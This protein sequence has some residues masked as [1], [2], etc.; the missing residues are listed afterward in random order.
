LDQDE[1]PRE[2]LRVLDLQGRWV[3]GDGAEREGRVAI[4]AEGVERVKADPPR[5]AED[6]DVE[7]E[8]RA[9]VAAA[10]EDR[11]QRDD[12]QE[13]ESDPEED[14]GDVMRDRQQPL[15]QP[16]PAA[17]RRVE[18]PFD[19]HRIDGNVWHVLL[20]LSV[21]RRRVPAWR[22]PPVWD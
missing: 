19:A 7:V 5:P 6:T 2:P 16:E 15:D 20:L 21:R 22:R 11:E 10:E 4:C 13:Q 8:D 3:V 9:W 1:A 17:E 12:G 18:L 14:E